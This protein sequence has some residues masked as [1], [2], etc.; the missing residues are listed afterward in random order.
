MP[1]PIPSHQK[2]FHTCLRQGLS[3][4]DSLDNFYWDEPGLHLLDVYQQRVTSQGHAEG[5]CKTGPIM[6]M[7][8]EVILTPATNI[9]MKG[10]NPMIPDNVHGH[11]HGHGILF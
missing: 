3:L 5:R 6:G 8:C 9:K 11:G 1:A 4:S 2:K 10:M 7:M